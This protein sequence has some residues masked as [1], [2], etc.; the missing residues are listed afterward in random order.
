M[1]A[2]TRFWPKYD[3]DDAGLNCTFGESGGPGLPCPAS[4]CSPPVDSKFEATFGAADGRDW[5]NSSHVDGWTLP[6][7]AEFN[8]AGDASNTADLNC[9]GLNQ[10]NC[11][12]QEIVGAGLDVSLS[13][14]NPD[15]GN[16]YAGC[17]SP[18]GLLTYTNWNNQYGNFTPP[19]APADQY[20][21]AGAFDTNPTCWTGPNPTMTY[22]DVIHANCDS[23]AW[24][25]D[26]AVGLKAR[27]SENVDFCLTFYTP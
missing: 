14:F 18:C 12:S 16:Q 17:Y 13:A 9:Q 6:Y 27:P 4:G 26:D 1:I 8:C 23:Y 21:C 20:C 10:S 5:Y 24:A 3:C 22:T 11:P 2:A 7:Q 25:Y 19:Q 15:K